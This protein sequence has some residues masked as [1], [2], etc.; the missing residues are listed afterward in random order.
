VDG[1]RRRVIR[2]GH[3]LQ[4][5]SELEG[6]EGL[7]EPGVFFTEGELAR[8]LRAKDP[9][10]T[11]AGIFAAK[12][13]LFKALP[14]VEGHLWSEMEVCHD[15][16]HAPF[17]RFHGPLG[18][19]VRER[20]YDVSLSISHSGAYASS[21]VAVTGGEVAAP[22][23]AE[24]PHR[25]DWEALLEPKEH[26]TQLNVRPSDFDALGHVNNAVAVQYLE[27]GRTDWLRSRRGARPPEPRVLAVVARAELNYRAE[28]RDEFVLV[29][30][31]IADETREAMEDG[32]VYKAT[33][34]QSIWV[35]RGDKRTL[36]VDAKVEIGFVR[37][38]DRTLCTAQD[39][40]ESYE[41]DETR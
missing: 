10:A 20:G 32:P 21:V 18:E 15:R 5:T 38:A 1:A 19:H 27:A 12:E 16:R 4:I 17:F 33:F 37:A 40:L 22:T 7:G 35:Q 11:M 2:L 14:G 13:A 9:K 26:T 31:C 23:K 3:D 25:T 39:F 6:I 29:T 28:I 30:T 36:A 41:A 24:E 34:L 8:V